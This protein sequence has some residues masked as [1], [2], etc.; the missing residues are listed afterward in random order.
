MARIVRHE[1][2]APMEVK[3]GGESKWIC[4]CGL[5]KSMPFCDGTH[6]Q[7]SGEKEGKVYRYKDGKRAEVKE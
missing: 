5:S 7:C 6:K 1:N 4:M 2:A 3:V